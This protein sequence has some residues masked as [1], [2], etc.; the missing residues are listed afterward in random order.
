M[1]E[2]VGEEVEEGRDFRGQRGIGRA[3]SEE[4]EESGATLQRRFGRKAKMRGQG[5][6]SQREIGPDRLGSRLRERERW[7]RWR[8]RHRSVRRGGKSEEG[9]AGTGVRG[10]RE[11]YGIVGGRGKGE[12]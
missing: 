4:E 10:G 5:S 11:E 7:G 1:Q 8:W 3:A 12:A 6:E 2:R 9:Y